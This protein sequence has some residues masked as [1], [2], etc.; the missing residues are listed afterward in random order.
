MDRLVNLKS[1]LAEIEDGLRIVLCD[2]ESS[3]HFEFPNRDPLPAT[4]GPPSDRWPP[5]SWAMPMF[6]EL[7][8]IIY[9]LT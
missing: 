7:G 4:F 1:L 3:K 9:A 6:A 5:S 8:N 2:L